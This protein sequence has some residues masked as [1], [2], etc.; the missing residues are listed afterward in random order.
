MVFTVEETLFTDLAQG[1]PEFRRKDM[2]DSRSFT[3]NRIESAAAPRCGVR[4]DDGTTARRR[5]RTPPARTSI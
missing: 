5:G 3:A 1:L 2:F 4:Q